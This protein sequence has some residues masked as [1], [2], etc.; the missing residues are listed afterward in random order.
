M[1]FLATEEIVTQTQGSA[2]SLTAE[3]EAVVQAVPEIVRAAQ[4]PR[5]S[6]TRELG[7]PQV[8]A[9]IQLARA[10]GMTMGE[11]ARRMG[12]SCAAATQ[13]VD[14]L[15]SLGLVVRERPDWDR[16]VVVVRLTERATATVREALAQRARQVEEVLGQLTEEEARGFAKGIQLLAEVLVRDLDRRGPTGSRPAPAGAGG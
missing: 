13:I 2:S 5:G 8:R 9:L 4:A 3:V 7:V 1:K 11:L 12:V 14:Q 15:V 16:R 10:D 6:A